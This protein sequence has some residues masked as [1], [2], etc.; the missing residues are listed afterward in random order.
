MYSD[1]DPQNKAN[2]DAQ[3]DGKGRANPIL[4]VDLDDLKDFYRS[5]PADWLRGL[6]QYKGHQLDENVPAI[7]DEINYHLYQRYN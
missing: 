2:K 3:Q 4:I 6:L 5:I 7:L 1:M